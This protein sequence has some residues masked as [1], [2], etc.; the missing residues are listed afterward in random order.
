MWLAYSSVS[1]HWFDKLRHNC[2]N[3]MPTCDGIAIYSLALKTHTLQARAIHWRINRRS[4]CCCSCCLCIW[5]VCVFRIAR[6]ATEKQALSTI[7]QIM[8]TSYGQC[9]NM[10]AALCFLLLVSFM[11]SFL[12]SDVSEAFLREVQWVT[13][14]AGSETWMNYIIK[15]VGKQLVVWLLYRYR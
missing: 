7:G 15:Q 6:P 11:V 1:L 2:N 10:C 5:G 13:V 12:L 14:E 8:S 9:G 4:N 3:I